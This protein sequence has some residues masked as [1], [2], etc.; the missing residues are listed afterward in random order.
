MAGQSAYVVLWHT[1]GLDRL[2]PEDS[3]AAVGAIPVFYEGVLVGILFAVIAGVLTGV[4]LR[5][6]NRGRAL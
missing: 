1:A 5:R 3:I 4:L 2:T 6:Q